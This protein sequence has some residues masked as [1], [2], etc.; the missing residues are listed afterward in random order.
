MARTPITTTKE[1]GPER[2][3][4]ACLAHIK[5]GINL[6]HPILSLQ[7]L[8]RVS[9]ECR[10]MN[11]PL[12]LRIVKQKQKLLRNKTNILFEV[13]IKCFAM[14]PPSVLTLQFKM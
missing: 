3:K 14:L 12:V 11:N 10:A 9:L 8:L 2:G 13:S 7:A 6:Q 5:P 4:D 1:Q